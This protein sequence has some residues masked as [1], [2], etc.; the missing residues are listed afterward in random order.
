MAKKKKTKTIGKLKKDLQPIFNKYIRLR[1]CQGDAGTNCISCGKWFKYEDLQAGHYYAVS[2]YN[3]LRFDENNV[4]AEC[5]RCNCFDESHL[6]GYGKNLKEK[7]SPL[8]L[9]LLHQNAID[10]KK[11]GYKFT[12]SELEDLITLYK[13]KIMD[14]YD[15]LF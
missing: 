14:V 2:G 12:R 10:Y 1:D 3:G 9:D 7:I 4:H 11:N 5:K 13:G 8:E 15:N 6:I